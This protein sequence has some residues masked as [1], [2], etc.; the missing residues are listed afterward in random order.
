MKY[1]EKKSIIIWFFL[2]LFI[3]ISFLILISSYIYPSILNIEEEKDNLVEKLEK[4]EKLDEKWFDFKDFK[5][6]N[7]IYSSK[8]IDSETNRDIYK[9][10]ELYEILN[11]Q[12]Y[13][14]IYTTLNEAFYNN[15]IYNWD[16]EKFTLSN[17]SFI[18]Y[19]D[20]SDK[21]LEQIKQSERFNNRKWNLSVV[22]PK[23]SSYIELDSSKDLTDLKFINSLENLLKKFNLKTTSPIGIKNIF[24]VNNDIVTS[25]D[26]IYYIPLRLDII[27]TKLWI[28][29]FLDYIKNSWDIE[30]SEND[31]NFSNKNG[32]ISQLVEVK[33]IEM[34]SYIDS[35]LEKRTSTDYD[36]KEFLVRT[37]QNN[38]V[39]KVI[40]DLNFYV[41]GISS[42]KIINKINS[43][44][45]NNL[46]K[47]KVDKYWNFEKD[48]KTWVYKQELLHYNYNNILKI[49]KKLKGNV[50]L[51]KN[52]YYNKK[53][54]NMFLYLNNK[55]LK[56]DIVA[57]KKELKNSKDLNSLYIKALKYKEIFL[58]LDREIYMIVKSLGIKKEN[59][60]FKSYIFE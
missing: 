20:K 54:N 58:K 5:Y 45:W 42:E 10:K 40:A 15:S 38:D 56:K 9:N 8:W 36:L 57:I 31:F 55:D 12:F 4:L 7:S 28:L 17:S 14:K 21:R 11:E 27:W 25:K 49:V 18:E 2:T 50:A 16:Y 13:K 52:W 29:E 35:R 48:E 22:L 46:T 59:I 60:Y 41:S 51:Q 6:L 34:K 32:E 47:I 26:D 23:Y 3:S 44:I 30:F 19:L 53:V 24:S 37:G 1:I 43:V 33:K 39:I